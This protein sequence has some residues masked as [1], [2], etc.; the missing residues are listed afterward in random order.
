[1]ADEERERLEAAD[2]RL[3]RWQ[4]MGGSGRWGIGVAVDIE[5][6]E[7]RLAALESSRSVQ[8]APETAAEGAKDPE[9]DKWPPTDAE[10]RAIRRA[11]AV[12]REMHDTRLE[13]ALGGLL[14]RLG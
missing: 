4:R 11:A 2:E 7:A 10:L 12:A 9:R 8:I 6:I 13:A 5:A 1:M 3:R 14:E